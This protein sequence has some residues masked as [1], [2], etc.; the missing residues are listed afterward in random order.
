MLSDFLHVHL[1]WLLLYTYKKKKI[2]IYLRSKT[3]KN[4]SRWEAVKRGL[5]EDKDGK[6]RE[7][8][9]TMSFRGFSIQST[10][11]S[12]FSVLTPYCHSRAADGSHPDPPSVRW[13]ALS[14]C[15]VGCRV[16]RVNEA[17]DECGGL[18]RQS[19]IHS[20]IA[21]HPRPP[22]FSCPLVYSSC[23]M[24]SLRKSYPTERLEYWY[25]SKV[26]FPPT[27]YPEKSRQPLEIM[28]YSIGRFCTLHPYTTPCFVVI[29]RHLLNL[30][31]C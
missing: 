26:L 25:Q 31:W 29:R 8:K 3:K 14:G 13:L 23:L 6:T 5:G 12:S 30:G 2:K 1:R 18:C 27:S 28:H 24:A 10:L 21:N 7:E 16:D 19:G 15:L 11:F 4:M 17:G 20:E 22:F 9:A